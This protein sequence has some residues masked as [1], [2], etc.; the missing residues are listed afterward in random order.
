MSA[1]TWESYQPPS[2]D[3]TKCI[4][5]RT[6]EA[7]EL[8]SWAPIVYRPIQCL[9]AP[10]ADGSGLC[11]ECVELKKRNRKGSTERASWQGIVTD[12]NSFPPWSHIAG[13]E[14]CRT[15][16]PGKGRPPK[17]LGAEK[18]KM[19][20]KATVAPV[21]PPTL[22]PLPPLL[23]SFD[24]PPPS[25]TPAK[26]SRRTLRRLLEAERVAHEATK[27]E[28]ARYKAS[29]IALLSVAMMAAL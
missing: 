5:R 27:Q 6:N 11:A 3:T 22:P 14:W 19:V 23:E 9:A 21:E 18:P 26:P 4:G 28:F 1:P 13:S 20:R 7:N 10:L 17:W 8:R 15:G 24:A 12:M 2:I 25:T 16:L 29:Q